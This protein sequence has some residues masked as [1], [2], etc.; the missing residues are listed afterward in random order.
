MKAIFLDRDGTIN[1][2]TG[3]LHEKKKL[4]FLPGCLETLKVLSDAG[5]MLFIVT[6]Q[7]GIGRGLFSQEEYERFTDYMKFEMEKSGVIIQQVY[8]CPHAPDE[9]CNCRKPKTGLFHQA[10]K[11]WNIDWEESYAIGDRM[12]DLSICLETPVKGILLAQN[13]YV[14]EITD[15]VVVCNDWNEI[16]KFILNPNH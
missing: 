12:R 15:E 9:Q 11:D 13:Q 3:Y 10:K 4:Q 5:Y 6:N 8:T 1:I 14:E 7:S 2:D 16:K